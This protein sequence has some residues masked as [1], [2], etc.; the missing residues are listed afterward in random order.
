MLD[1]LL[2]LEAIFSLK[3][4]KAFGYRAPPR[5]K[6]GRGLTAVPRPLAGFKAGKERQEREGGKKQKRGKRDEGSLP[7]HQVLGPPLADSD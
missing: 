6:R 3:T 1:K 7:Y 2:Q 4:Q 5:P